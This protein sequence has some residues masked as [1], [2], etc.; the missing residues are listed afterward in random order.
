MIPG[1]RGGRSRRFRTLM[2]LV[3]LSVAGLLMGCEGSP[4]EVVLEMPELS[5]VADGDYRA[6]A[7]VPPVIVRVEVSVRDGRITDFRVRRHLTGQGQAAEALAERVVEMQT[8]QLDAV[9]GAT[10]SSKAILKAGE[11][12][13]R[14]GIE[15]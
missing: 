12:A 3:V 15:P 2:V 10:Y 11:K 1:A 14:R 8:I 9:T 5:S 7:S 13:L 6:T 4:D